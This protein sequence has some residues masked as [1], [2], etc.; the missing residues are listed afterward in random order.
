M[1]SSVHLN[2]YR[3]IKVTLAG[4][5]I[6]NKFKLSKLTGVMEGSIL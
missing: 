4:S 1:F 5:F 6:A 2:Y 3:R